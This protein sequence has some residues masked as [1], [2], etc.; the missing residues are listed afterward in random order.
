MAADIDHIVAAPFPDVT[1]F[2]HRWPP[3]RAAL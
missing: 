1:R 2:E 3:F